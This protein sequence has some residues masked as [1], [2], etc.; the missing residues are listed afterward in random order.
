MEAGGGAER[1]PAAPAPLPAPAARQLTRQTTGRGGQTD[2]MGLGDR[3]GDGLDVRTALRR[4]L[5]FYLLEV[6]IS[7]LPRVFYVVDHYSFRV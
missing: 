4:N 1:G 5:P 2:W 6:L 7:L 3:L